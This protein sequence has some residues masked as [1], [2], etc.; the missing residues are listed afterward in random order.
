MPA[1]RAL[2]MQVVLTEN[3]QSNGPL[4]IIPGSHRKF[5]VCEGETPPQHYRFS[6]KKQEHGVPSDNCIEQLVAAGGIVTATGKPGSVIIFDCNVMHG[7]NGNTTPFPRS[8]AFFVYNAL[9]NRVLDP[10]G[11][12]PPRPEHL[13]TR[14]QINPL[15][16]SNTHHWGR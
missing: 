5:V 16:I 1:M 3:Y 8:N 15:S 4:M 9:S 6:L 14:Q 12:H 10:F 7:S 11:D 2:S 13:C